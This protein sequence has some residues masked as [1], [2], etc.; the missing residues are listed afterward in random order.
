MF[1]DL[2]ADRYSCLPRAAEAAFLRFAR[3]A[4]KP[5]DSSRLAALVERGM[6]VEDAGKTRPGLPT[7][8][9]PAMCDLTRDPEINPTALDLLHAI[10]TQLKWACI[11][12]MRPLAQIAAGAQLRARQHRPTCSELGHYIGR[13]IAAFAA[14]SI[15]LPSADRCLVRALAMHDLCRRA[16][17]HPLVIFGVRMNP[18][19]AHCWVQLDGKVLIGDFEQVRLFTPIAAFG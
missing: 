2:V 12:R 10:S 14:T 16:G 4:E 8:I 11:L 18:F 15:I 3:G 13:I 6:L 1:L 19:L 7:P 9:P 17:I 5:G